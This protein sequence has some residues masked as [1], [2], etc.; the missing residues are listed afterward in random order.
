MRGSELVGFV[1]VGYDGRRATVYHLYVIDACRG[2][3]VGEDLLEATEKVIVTCLRMGLE[4]A[5]LWVC[6]VIW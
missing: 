6:S 5:S 3:G 1:Y 2:A 4:H